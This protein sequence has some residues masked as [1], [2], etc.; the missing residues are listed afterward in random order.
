MH[1]CRKICHLV[2]ECQASLARA[3]VHCELDV[4]RDVLAHLQYVAEVSWLVDCRCWFVVVVFLVL[5][6][7]KLS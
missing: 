1:H 5:A 6:D 2:G 4:E 7:L 3:E